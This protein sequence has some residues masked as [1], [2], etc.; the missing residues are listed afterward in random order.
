MTTARLQ[1]DRFYRERD[2]RTT[3]YLEDE[4]PAAVPI[5]IHVSSDA[6]ETRSGQLLLMTLVNQL[7]RLHRDLR[8]SLSVPDAVLLIPSVCGGSSVGDELS[9]MTSRIDPFGKFEIDRSELTPAKVS[10]GIGAG[11]RSGL[12]WYLGCN[13]S[14]AELATA[15]RQVGHSTP[16]DLR[17]AGLAAVL[18]AAAVAKTVLGIKTVPTTLSAWNFESGAGADPGPSELPSVDVGKGLMIGAGA[19]SNAAVY[20]LTQWGNLS[21]WTIVDGDIVKLHNTNRCLL[22]FPDDAGWP[23]SNPPYSKAK[24]LSRYLV[25]AAPVNAWYDEVAGTQQTFD[26]VLVLANERDVRSRVSVRNDPIQLQATT[27]R[28]WL[29]QLHRHISGRDDCVR[30]RM[31]DVR[32]PQFACS[33]AATATGGQ[34]ERPDAALPFC[35]LP[36]V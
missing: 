15:P 17:G 33:E 10:I 28:S 22:F 4:F 5:S 13:L 32:T 25:D 9:K 1:A 20:W 16:G 35:P 14:N 21:P 8:V 27:G 18:G 12:R 24:C 29:S 11:A 26:T 7:A 6:C 34:P 23:D 36:V 2:L 3:V 19:V 31:S 30:C